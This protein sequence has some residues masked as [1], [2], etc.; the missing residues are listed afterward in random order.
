[1][2]KCKKKKKKSTLSQSVAKYS[3]DLQTL[4]VAPRLL[5]P[6]KD[7]HVNL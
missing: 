5:A 1:M 4:S 2:A 7:M 6:T 3:L